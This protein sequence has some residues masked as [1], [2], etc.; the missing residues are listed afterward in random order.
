MPKRI[1]LTGATG[2]VGRAVLRHLS[3]TES[4]VLAAVRDPASAG[5]TLPPADKLRFVPFDFG[6]PDT[7]GPVLQDVRA[8]FLLRPPMLA[9]VDRYF[10]PLLDEIQQ[11]NIQ[12]LIFLSVQGADK[13]RFIPHA[14]IEAQIRERGIP[15]IFLRPSYF[16]Q[17]LTTTLYAGIREK[18]KVEIPAGD[19]VFNWVDVD[20]IGEV[21]ALLL[22]QPG[23]HL[24]RALDITGTENLSFPQALD[25]VNRVLTHPIGYRSVNPLRYLWR[26]TRRGASFGNALTVAAIHYLQRFQAVAPVSPVYRE[27]TGK[28]PTTLR[29]FAQRERH[30]LDPPA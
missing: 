13:S 12:H 19:A 8:V 26:A 6:Q 29:A 28:A 7:F 27:L 1:L 20:N 14:K 9:D 15:Y 24:N 3:N 25:R 17:N 22:E 4:E 23:S 5:A 2:N 21:A 30:L 18:R 11:Q 16:M 10:V